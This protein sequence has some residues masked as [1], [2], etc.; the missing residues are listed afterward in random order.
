[1]ASFMLE[2]RMIGNYEKLGERVDGCGNGLAEV[3]AEMEMGWNAVE[4]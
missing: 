4:C 1:M 3:E 2:T